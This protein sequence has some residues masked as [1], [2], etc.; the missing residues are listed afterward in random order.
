MHLLHHTRVCAS[1]LLLCALVIGSV[2][3]GRAQASNGQVNITG[4]IV[5]N[6][7]EISVDDRNKTVDMGSVS[8]KQFTKG[9]T[10]ALPKAFTLSLVNCGPTAEGMTVG[11]QGAEDAFRHDLLALDNDGTSA[12]GMGIAILDGNQAPVPVNTRTST[13]SVQPNANLIVLRFYAQYTANGDEVRA[14]K[15]NATATFDFIYD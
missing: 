1:A 15:A 13:Y 3:S 8:A 4:N 2:V 12:T 10:T 9:S 14:G 5:S 6:T 7:C 11:F